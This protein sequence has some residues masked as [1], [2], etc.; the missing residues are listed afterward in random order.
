MFFCFLPPV[1]NITAASGITAVN[2]WLGPLVAEGLGRDE[3]SQFISDQYG[4][5]CTAK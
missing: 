5:V 2:S 1:M 3:L 4:S